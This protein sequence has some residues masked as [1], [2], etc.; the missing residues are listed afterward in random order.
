MVVTSRAMLETIIKDRGPS[1]DFNDLDVSNV[2]DFSRLFANMEFSGKIDRWNMSSAIDISGMFQNAVFTGTLANWD[3]VNVKRAAFAFAGASIRHLDV[4]QWQ[5]EH[6][7]DGTGMFEAFRGVPEV[8]SWRPLKLKYARRM[9]AGCR[10]N[11]DVGT[12]TTGWLKYADEMFA[13][14]EINRKFR[15]KTG[16]LVSAKDAFRDTPQVPLPSWAY[17]ENWLAQS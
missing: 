12:W 4:S 10:C 17:E 9:F 2:T 15:W 8:G 6:L 1:A 14:S 7:E 16:R 13:G 5:M 11:P 3:P